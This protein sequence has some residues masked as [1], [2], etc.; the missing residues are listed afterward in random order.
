MASVLGA[1]RDQS[2]YDTC[3]TFFVPPLPPP[4]QTRNAACNANLE[5]A[6]TAVNF[7]QDPFNP[8]NLYGK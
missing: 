4:H 2:P 7:R 1:V 8:P 5:V 3:K 6:G